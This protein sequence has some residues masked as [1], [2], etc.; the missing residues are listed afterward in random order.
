MSGGDP[1]A[2]DTATTNVR[3][4]EIADIRLDWIDC[5]SGDM[6]F[7]RLAKERKNRYYLSRD[8]MALKAAPAHTETLSG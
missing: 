1:G 7:V 8:Q 2:P 6:T 4:A 5:C 3:H